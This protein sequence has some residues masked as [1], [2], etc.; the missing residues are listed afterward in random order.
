[1]PGDEAAVART[2]A[3][4]PCQQPSPPPPE[5]EPDAIDKIRSF[6]EARFRLSGRAA[7]DA[8]D[9]ESCDGKATSAERFECRVNKCERRLA[10]RV[11]KEVDL[12]HL[13]AHWRAG[14]FKRIV[15]MVG[16][17]ISTCKCGRRCAE[18]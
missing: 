15:T 10:A 5:A 17:G 16:A 4:A 12:E 9:T 11:L 7:D 6:F 3:S 8:S 18:W 2:T 13:V 1:M 14:G